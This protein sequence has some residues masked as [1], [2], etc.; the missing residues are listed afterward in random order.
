MISD[1]VELKKKLKRTWT[2]FFSR[3]GKLLP[4][5]LKTIPV[6]L[7]GKNA[8]I[9]SST[10]SGKT[11]AVVAP[12]IERHLKENWKDLSILYISPTRALVND[13]YYRL[14][15]QLDD[16]NVS[17]SLKTGDKPQFN[18]NKTPNFLITTP[19]SFDSLICRYPISFKNIK[20][21]ILDEIHLLDNTYR[22]D[23][24]RI[25]LMR[26]EYIA[27]TNFNIYALSATIADPE[28]VGSRY[29]M[30]FEVIVSHSK[31]EIVYTL[32]RSLREVFNYARIEKLRKLL[33][34]CNKRVNVED[35]AK[36]CKRLWGDNRV[37][38]HHGSLSKQI[39]EEAESFMKETQYGVCIATMTLEIGIDIG[40]IDAVVLAEVP[41]SISSLL[42]RIGRG[43]RRT[44]KC[45][46]FAIYNSEDERLIF[47]RMFK[48]AMEGYVEPVEYSPD[49]S[50]VVQ[51]IFSLL[52]AN[53][54]GLEDGYFIELFDEFCSERDLKDILS[55]LAIKGWIEKR[56]NKWYAT[57]KLMDWGE[58]GK[59]HSNIPSI[60]TLK[61]VDI[62]SKQIIGEVQYPI[63]DIF[64]L[65]GKVWKV[66][67]VLNDKIYVKS[68]ESKAS[69]AKFKSHT[70][71]GYFY[72]FLPKHIREKMGE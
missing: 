20:A 67:H 54:N 6:V 4:I 29:L 16:L 46:V 3:Y 7:E 58:K 62:S 60:K 28:D 11:E 27:A 33:I 31:R 14:K 42:Q 40:D 5:Q 66:V 51:Q 18:L 9:V 65:A 24:L 23:Q 12:L 36:E 37:V 22:G 55:H 61:V 15:E 30:D 10:A 70:S 53:P 44:Q 52:Y 72:Y 64:V 13:M 69:T 35:V 45:R 68:E 8:I 25:L 19:E 39:R 50:V 38:V 17:L 32:V 26:L 57:T 63:D 21:V 48:I 47:E 41:W 71:K 34:F 56:Y 2:I 49:L 43:N 1:Q 59:I